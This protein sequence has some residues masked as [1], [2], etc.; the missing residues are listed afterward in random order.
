MADKQNDLRDSTTAADNATSY[1]IRRDIRRTRADMDETVDALGERLRPRHLLD[2]V[3]DLFR[4]SRSSGG[5]E[6][7]SGIHQTADL[8]KDLGATAMQKLKHHPVPAA[9]IGAGIA[10][11]LFDERS[12]PNR[13]SVRGRWRDGELREYSGSYVD[14]RTGRP[15]E[16]SY[17]VDYAQASPGESA[18]G[19]QGMMSKAADAAKSAG[20]KVAGAASSVADA[21]SSARE[22]AADYAGRAGSAAS[23]Y[24]R[25]ARDFSGQ[26]YGS[27]A[28]SMRRGADIGR[29][30][31]EQSLNE[32]PL[33]VVAAAFAS[34][35]LAGMVCPST[36]RENQL[37]GEQSDALKESVK[38]TFKEKGKEVADATK[39]VANAAIGAA[40][41]EA[42]KQ[43]VTPGSLAEKVK[44]VARDT[45]GAARESARREGLTDVAQK[46][47]DVAERAKEA[48]KD[49]ARQH[50]DRIANP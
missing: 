4:G 28:Y 50:K 5:G 8:A 12:G 49:Q 24:S 48:A 7:S 23:H 37:M 39:E 45:V 47:K 21:A 32:Y 2:D 38:E 6:S 27:A 46:G 3:I 13:D 40:T 19:G 30:S 9:L 29:R 11:L 10:W 42:D 34:G 41:E 25:Q 44:H 17:G 36:R 31:F 14:A 35:M 22:T 43:G 33:A 20:Q 15:Y 18:G 16:E 26:A 1:E